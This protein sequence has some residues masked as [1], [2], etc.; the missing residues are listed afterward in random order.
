MWKSSLILCSR[1][2]GPRMEGLCV[3]AWVCLRVCGR[4]CECAWVWMNVRLDVCECRSVS[5]CTW[6]WM[7]DGMCVDSRVCLSVHD[8]VCSNDLQQGEH[9][10][11]RGPSPRGVP[12][13]RDT[14]GMVQ[15]L[16]SDFWV[17]TPAP[18][19]Q[20]DNPGHSP[21]AFSNFPS[22]GPPHRHVEGEMISWVR[23]RGGGC[24]GWTFRLKLGEKITCGSVRSLVTGF[25]PALGQGSYL[26]CSSS[27]NICQINILS[28][29][30]QWFFSPNMRQQW[31]YE[32]V[33][34]LQREWSRLCPCEEP[35]PPVPYM[36]LQRE[37][38][39]PSLQCSQGRATLWGWPASSSTRRDRADT[40]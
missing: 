39:A 18:P 12:G 8:W 3:Q 20:Q 34:T 37:G 33:S 24:G 36:M 30:K 23:R 9:S 6:M 40:V 11:G 22:I 29:Y 14:L 32:T 7:W 27:T 13:H 17:W 21:W 5:V 26:S 31:S 16:P 19:C 25:V 38:T 1:L 35:C 4:V 28:L 2:L 15:H 10:R